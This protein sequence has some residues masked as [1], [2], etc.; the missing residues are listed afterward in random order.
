MLNTLAATFIPKLNS[1]E[2]KQ[3]NVWR[4]V[5]FFVV[6]I[7]LTKV[8]VMLTT[9]QFMQNKENPCHVT[10]YNKAPKETCVSNNYHVVALLCIRVLLI[11]AAFSFFSS[12]FLQSP[13]DMIA[14]WLIVL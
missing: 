12:F 8:D 13:R 6:W 1:V 11:I 7:I 9:A 14:D 3:K 4:N 10:K 2:T 5:T